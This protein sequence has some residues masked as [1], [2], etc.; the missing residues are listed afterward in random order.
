MSINRVTD[1]L[2]SIQERVLKEGSMS[3]ADFMRYNRLRND[4]SFYARIERSK[5]L[6][7]LND[8]IKR[9]SKKIELSFFYGM[10][11]GLALAFLIIVLCCALDLIPL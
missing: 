4:L 1:E 7:E 8:K 9:I 2:R 11:A 6:N 3:E 5:E 10:Y